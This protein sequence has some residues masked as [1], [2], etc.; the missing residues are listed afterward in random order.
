MAPKSSTPAFDAPCRLS[1]TF[2]P[3]WSGRTAIYFPPLSPQRYELFIASV[4][5]SAP[6]F[7][8]EDFSSVIKD[9]ISAQYFPRP[10]HYG[11]LGSKYKKTRVLYIIVLHTCCVRHYSGRATFLSPQIDRGTANLVNF[12]LVKS[13]HLSIAVRSDFCQKGG[14]WE[15]GAQF[16]HL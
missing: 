6:T 14:R 13:S 1:S 5:Y 16:S 4:L 11:W 8:R 10:D 15:T 7:S 12:R 9:S 3:V 2:E